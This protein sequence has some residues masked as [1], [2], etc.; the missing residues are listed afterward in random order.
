MTSVQQWLDMVSS[1]E[2]LLF[3]YFPWAIILSSLPASV[4]PI[5]SLYFEKEA[6]VLCSN[7][8][9]REFFSENLSQ[10]FPNSLPSYFH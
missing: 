4:S 3:C 2:G 7:L 5:P 9:A 10:Q 1:L 6:E 8:A